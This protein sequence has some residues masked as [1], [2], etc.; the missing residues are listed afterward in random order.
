MENTP[1]ANA[2]QGA[3]S[4][5]SAGDDPETAMTQKPFFDEVCAKGGRSRSAL[6]M[7]ASA[8]N[9]ERAKKVLAEKRQAKKQSGLIEPRAYDARLPG[10]A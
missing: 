6:K 9:L 2:R 3:F 10:A 8:R 1:R 4:L 7:A 5:L